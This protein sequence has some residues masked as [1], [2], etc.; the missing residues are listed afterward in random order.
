VNKECVLGCYKLFKDAALP[1]FSTEQSACFDFKAYIKPGMDIKYYTENN[2]VEKM[3]I[4]NDYVLIGP[5]ERFLIPTGLILDIPEGYSVR[6]HPRS[7]NAL[8]KGIALA[9]CEGII[10]SDY[11]HMTYIV[12][13]NLSQDIV[14]IKDRDKI[15]QGELNKNLNYL[16][17]EQEVKPTQSTSR[18]GGFGSTD[19]K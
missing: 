13:I 10:D 15:A 5:Y 2:Q 9:N 18:I 6:L 14:K 3:E 12:L 8:K 16:I 1:E 4:K 11:Y 7:G 19:K 17:K